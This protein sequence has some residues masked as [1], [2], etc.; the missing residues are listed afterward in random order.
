[1]KIL[2]D[3]HIPYLSGVFDE[4]SENQ[5]LSPKDFSNIAVKDT[6]ALIIRTRTKADKL[7]LSNTK[8]KFIATATIGTDHIDKEFCA[9]NEIEWK[10]AAGCNSNSVNQY[11]TSIILEWLNKNKLG[12]KSVTAGIIGVGN[13]GKKLEHNLNILNVNTL[14]NDPLRRDNESNFEHKT[15]SEIFRQCDI[16]SFHV[17]L[18]RN[19]RYPTYHIIQKEHLELLKGRPVLLI[20]TSRGEVLSN[21]LLLWALGENPHLSLALDVWENEPQIKQELAQN[22]FF[23]SPHIAGYS[24]DG[25]AKGTEMSVQAVA[26]HFNLPLKNWKPSNIPAHPK[27]FIKIP[28]HKLG[29]AESLQFAFRHTYNIWNDDRALRN[30]FNSFES[31]RSSYPLRREFEH[32]HFELTKTDK[33]LTQTLVKL[34]FKSVNN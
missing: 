18:S 23:I 33:N 34:G 7:L 21:E 1:M 27:R 20:N 31:L 6:D 2:I 19:C 28:N 9:E 17:P 8:V 11:V 15:K 24:A 3:K 26:H 22:C 25:K 30:N 5:Y 12:L 10:N 4:H 13:V 32:F 29:F 14:T 16:I